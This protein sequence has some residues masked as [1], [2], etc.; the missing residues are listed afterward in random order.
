MRLLIAT[1]IFPP[2]HGGPARF[3][4]ELASA[5]ARRGWQVRVLTLADVKQPLTGNTDGAYRVLA[6]PRHWRRHRRVTAV[7]RYLHKGLKSSDVL[8]ANGLYEEA[9]LATAA[10]RTPWVAKVVGDSV[11]ERARNRGQTNEDIAAFQTV[12]LSTPLR[13]QRRI[14]SWSLARANTV[15]TPSNQ[16]ADIAERWGLQQPIVI[17]NGVPIKPQGAEEPQVD[18]VSV[19]RLVPWKGLDVLI[20]AC[21]EARLSL[22]IVGDGPLREHLGSLVDSLGAQDVVT[23]T[24]G[25]EP[26]DVARSLG[27]ARVFALN[28]S[29]EGMSFALLEARERGLPCV[30]GDN[31]G[32]RAVIRDGVDGFVVNPQSVAEVKDA[33]IRLVEDPVL[34]GEM[35]A[36]ARE[37]VVN[38]YSI[39]AATNATLDIIEEVAHGRTRSNHA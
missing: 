24:G 35:G 33:L 32:N 29:Y 10:A 18:V 2:D 21:S 37:D 30:V 34:A 39:D 17:P 15:V 25:V 19:C 3:V 13:L 36:R 11:W 7:T 28:S 23:F 38:R 4:P 20:H 14:L 12:D 9:A 26:N 27:R 5:A 22:D 6:V 1:G 16:L 31:P 8:F